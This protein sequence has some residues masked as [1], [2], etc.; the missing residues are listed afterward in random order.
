MILLL[1]VPKLPGFKVTCLVKEITA[2]LQRGYIVAEK[3]KSSYI[4]KNADR[5]R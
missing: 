4:A 5:R 3:R 1:P 2:I